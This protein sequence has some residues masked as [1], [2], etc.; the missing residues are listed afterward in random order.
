MNLT[1]LYQ[2][3]PTKTALWN[4]RALEVKKRADKLYNY[5]QELKL[6]VLTEAERGKSKAI[7]GKT[8]DRDEIVAIDDYDTPHQ[9]MI[10]NELTDKSEARKLK[11][12]IADFREFLLTTGKGKRTSWN[13]RHRYRKVWIRILLP[14][15]KERRLDPE[16]A[17]WEYHKFGHSPLMGFLAIMSSLQIDTAQCGIGYDQLPVFPDQCRRGKIQQARCR[18]DP[19]YQLCHQGS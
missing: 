11:K 7:K 6:K 10:G 15:K 9:V 2:V 3:N 5:I 8:I 14:Q 12:E 16:T 13:L 17:T 18:G 4:N 19:Q 1:R